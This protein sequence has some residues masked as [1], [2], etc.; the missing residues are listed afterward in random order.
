MQSPA[1]SRNAAFADLAESREERPCLPG[2]NEW[3]EHLQALAHR[4]ER[5]WIRPVGLL[6]GRESTPRGRCPGGFG[7]NY[8]MSV[9]TVSLAVSRACVDDNRRCA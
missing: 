8:S 6:E 5:R 4:V 7:A 9:E 1:W 2:E 3:R